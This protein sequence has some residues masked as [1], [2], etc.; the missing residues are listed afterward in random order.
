VTDATILPMLATQ[1]IEGEEALLHA[2][3]IQAED[4]SV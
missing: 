2:T 3:G 4:Y 1:R